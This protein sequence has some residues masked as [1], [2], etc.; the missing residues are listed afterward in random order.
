MSFSALLH[1]VS[2]SGSWGQAN[3]SL[4]AFIDKVADL[5]YEGVMLMAKRPHL[6]LLDYGPK[7]RAQLRQRLEKRKLR[8]LCIAGYNN[9]TGDLEHGEVYITD[10]ARLAHDLGGSLVRIFTA[11]ENP[12]VGY[13]AQW[14]L[15]VAALKECAK[16]AGEFGVT[17]GV[18][19]HHDIA[20]GYESQYDLIQAIG[21][22]NCKALFDAWAPA[23]HGED[24][25][26]AAR[27]MAPITPHTTIAA[28]QKRPRYHYDSAVVNYTTLT[29]Y[30]QAV[31]IDEGFVDYRKFLGA[32]R[33]GGFHGSIAYEMC[34]PLL[35]GGSME[36]LDRYATRFLE[37]VH[38]FRGRAGSVAAD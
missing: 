2:Y 38:D 36:N 30:I 34:S 3:L 26:A 11:Y 5:G 14:N 28:Y 4:D 31:P 1:S 21:E 18:Q 29:P 16:R 35:G 15:V 27:K 33:A 22:P 17:L 7:E 23:L 12:A 13:A 6:S 32:L 9:F 24:L 20:V 37:F 10:L 8:D 19:N 25:E